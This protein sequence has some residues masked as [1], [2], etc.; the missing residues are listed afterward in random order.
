MGSLS[1]PPLSVAAACAAAG[2]VERI[3]G[4]VHKL[5]RPAIPCAGVART[6][7]TRL[8]LGLVGYGAVCAFF[9]FMP[10]ASDTLG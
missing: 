6:I 5:A 1:A 4:I 7:L 3:W 8:L 9:P 2:C 10:E